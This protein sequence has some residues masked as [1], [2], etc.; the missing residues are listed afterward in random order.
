M[1]IDYRPEIDGLRAIAVLAVLF[2]H[3][4]F[5]IN[6]GT[7]NSIN[8]L[9]GGFLGVDIFFVVSGYLITKIILVE[10]LK[11]EFSFKNF[12]LNRARRLL[13]ALFLVIIFSIPFSW[14]YL[15]PKEMQDY[16]L[17]VIYSLLFS[18]NFLFWTEN[19]YFATENLLKPFLHTWS[20]AIEEQFY[21]IFPLSL[22][23]I[24]KF[25]REKII[26]IFIFLFF[27]SII[28]AQYLS[29]NSPEASFYLF[30]SRAWELL[31]G[32]ILANLELNKK[33]KKT[34]L[35][36][37]MP[38]IGLVLI[39]S[40]FIFMDSNIIHPSFIST[41]PIVGTAL[42]IWFGGKGDFS[43]NFLSKK[44]MVGIGLISYPLYLWHFPLFVYPR[45]KI[46]NLSDFDKF[47]SI[48]IS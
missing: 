32:A 41:I 22:V 27:L 33:P 6:Y 18:S 19:S 42:F 35:S 38:L 37:I 26:A 23:L 17:S 25:F 8:F 16:A 46:S 14:F 29:L 1:R 2:Y 9:P 7:H 30:P 4:E 5:V 20:L 24:W 36:R 21:L 47:E 3:A 12:Y 13:P 39:F 11:N 10:L 45:I 48:Y 40:S 34:S 28:I 31:T 43:S 44:I 15:M